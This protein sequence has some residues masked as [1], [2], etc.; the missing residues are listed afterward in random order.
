MARKH[1]S[2][3]IS[4]SADERLHAL[5]EVYEVP[6]TYVVRVCLAVASNHLD[7]VRKILT[8]VKDTQ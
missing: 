8:T 3:R 4:E 1:V 6:Y 7:E 2:I 5:A